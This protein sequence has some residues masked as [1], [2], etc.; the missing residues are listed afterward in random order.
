MKIL[1]A[2][3]GV[4]GLSKGQLTGI[5]IGVGLTLLAAL[6]IGK[7]LFTYSILLLSIYISCISTRVLVASVHF[8]QA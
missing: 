8:F 3:K 1:L 4:G 2:V 7:L 6:F 5:G